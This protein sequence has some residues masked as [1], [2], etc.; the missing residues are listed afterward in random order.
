MFGEVRRQLTF[1]DETK[2]K[3][4][5]SPSSFLSKK[6]RK[7]QTIYLDQLNYISNISMCLLK[8]GGG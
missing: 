1:T 8:T 2:K 4:K 7:N 3:K 5:K 6:K